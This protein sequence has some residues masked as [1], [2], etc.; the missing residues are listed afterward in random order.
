MSFK[1]VVYRWLLPAYRI[2]MRLL[3]GLTVGVRVMVFDAQGRILLIEHSYTPGWHMPGGGVERGESVE[4]AAVRELEEEAGVRPTGRLRLVSIHDN[5]RTFPGDH[6]LIY[7]LDD[8]EP[9]PPTARGEIL[10]RDWFDPRDLP[11]GATEGT[12]RRIAEALDGTPPG[13][14]W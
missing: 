1:R 2:A 9:T 8:W 6:V 14:H 7:R 11:P 12:R 13:L 5:G 10:R 4:E 3:R